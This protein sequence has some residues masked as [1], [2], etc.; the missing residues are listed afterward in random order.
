MSELTPPPTATMPIFTRHQPVVFRFLRAHHDGGRLD[1]DGYDRL[2]RVMRAFDHISLLLFPHSH[3][4]DSKI[5]GNIDK[6]SNLILHTLHGFDKHIASELENAKRA[7][8]DLPDLNVSEENQRF[9][10]S[11]E[12]RKVL[13]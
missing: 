1:V 8:R 11:K 6:V 13:L 2:H 5:Q 10:N 9:E 12:W 3:V 7:M 4:L